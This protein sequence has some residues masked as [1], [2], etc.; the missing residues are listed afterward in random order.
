MSRVRSEMVPWRD[1]SNAVIKIERGRGIREKTG[2][3]GK[4]LKHYVG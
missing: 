3:R 2:E 4:A 1:N